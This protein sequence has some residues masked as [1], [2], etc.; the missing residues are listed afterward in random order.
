[1]KSTLIFYICAFS[2]WKTNAK[3]TTDIIRPQLPPGWWENKL[4]KKI[5]SGY[6]DILNEL[7]FYGI[8]IFRKEYCSVFSPDDGRWD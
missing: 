5:L 4:Q 8:F 1:M 2:G 7:N 3:I 6:G